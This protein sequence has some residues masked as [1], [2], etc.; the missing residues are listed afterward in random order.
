M[1]FNTVYNI[2]TAALLTIIYLLFLVPQGSASEL[3]LD[4][5]SSFHSILFL[6]Y[7]GKAGDGRCN[8]GD[9][10]SSNGTTNPVEYSR[11]NNPQI[12]FGNTGLI[13]SWSPQIGLSCYNC[14]NPTLLQSAIN[15]GTIP[16]TYEILV[17]ASIE[18]QQKGDYCSRI[19]ID[20]QQRDCKEGENPCNPGEF[21]SSNGTTNPV[22]YSLCNNPQI[23]FQN[24]GLIYSWSPQVGLT[25]YDC[26]NPTLLQSE[27]HNNTIPAAYEVQVYVSLDDQAKG[28]YCVRYMIETRKGA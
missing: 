10:T 12:G 8:P 5:D 9:F 20:T 27:I 19:K 22:E 14:P 11:C 16:A 17:Y 26:P 3:F 28:K 6:D 21:M 18:D 25:C 4:K 2:R 1:N 23:G 24:T 15:N 7:D 13:Y